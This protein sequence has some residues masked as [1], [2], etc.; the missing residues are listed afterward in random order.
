MGLLLPQ[1]PHRRALQSA[2]SVEDG[3]RIF[4][5][6]RERG[7]SCFIVMAAA[8]EGLETLLAA[9]P[10]VL[11]PARLALIEAHPEWNQFEK[12]AAWARGGT[13]HSLADR[14][15]VVSLYALRLPL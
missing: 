13:Q 2:R 10:P 12:V 9:K 1:W 8:L 6:A 5:N 4:E 3:I 11:D 14:D 7:I 15:S